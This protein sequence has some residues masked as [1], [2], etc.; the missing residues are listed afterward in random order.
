MA[1]VES[2]DRLYHNTG[3]YV[4]KHEYKGMKIEM[5]GMDVF[6]VYTNKIKKS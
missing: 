4:Y 2:K 3:N 1:S 6:Y 5:V